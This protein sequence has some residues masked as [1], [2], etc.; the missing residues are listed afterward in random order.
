MIFLN[1]YMQFFYSTIEKNSAYECGF[2][3]FRFFNTN[4]IIHFFFIGLLYIIFDIEVIFLFLIIYHI[5]II[6][7]NG[8]YT[9]L[10]MFWILIIGWYI[11]IKTNSLQWVQRKF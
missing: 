4:Y 9:I 10:S 5:I 8:F 1:Y 11:E 3:P 7:L 2:L 6:A